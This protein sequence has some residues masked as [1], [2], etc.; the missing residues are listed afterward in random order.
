[1]S[2]SQEAQNHIIRGSLCVHTKCFVR[3]TVAFH[4]MVSFGGVGRWR[5]VIERDKLSI[6]YWLEIVDVGLFFSFLLGGH[7][8]CS[9]YRYWTCVV[10]IGGGEKRECMRR[11]LG[12]RKKL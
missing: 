11:V 5:R 2:Y 12:G 6:Q 7:E 3:R 8:G 9:W 4:G 10:Q 1:M